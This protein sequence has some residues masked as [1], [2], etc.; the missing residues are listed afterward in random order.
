MV[1]VLV[2][3]ANLAFDFSL[4]QSDFEDKLIELMGPDVDFTH[5][6]WDHY[7]SSL[8][9]YAA[10]ND[11]RLSA[12]CQKF[13][14]DNGFF[15]IFV[16]HQDGWET[17]YSWTIKDTENGFKPKK[18]WRRK[19]KQSQ[20]GNGPGWYISYWPEGWGKRD[21]LETGYMVIVPDPLE[22]NFDN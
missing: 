22:Q 18:G 16:N 5:I 9:I 8:E 21:W 4:A 1:E 10:S 15:L 7:D 13:I 6:G 11:V 2:P 17:H 20:D 3:F 14:Y 19:A 12:E